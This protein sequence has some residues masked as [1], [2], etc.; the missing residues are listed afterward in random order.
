M[1]LVVGDTRPGPGS[2]PKRVMGL[3]KNPMGDSEGCLG[4]VRAPFATSPARRAWPNPRSAPRQSSGP[5]HPAS[6]PQRRPPPP[7]A[8]HWRQAPSSSLQLL[9]LPAQRL[10]C[11]HHGGAVRLLIF[12]RYLRLRRRGPEASSGLPVEMAAVA[13]TEAGNGTAKA[14]SGS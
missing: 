14:S 12:S 9:K 8:G 10:R 5:P 13:A 6:T 1:F 11:L 3:L 2:R 4:W 7:V